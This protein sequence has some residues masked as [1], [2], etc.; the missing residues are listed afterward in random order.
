MKYLTTIIV[1]LT[2]F[3]CMEN[4]TDPQKEKSI[5]GQWITK[6]YY[7]GIIDITYNDNILIIEEIAGSTGLPNETYKTIESCNNI[8]GQSQDYTDDNSTYCYVISI[9]VYP[10]SLLIKP[11]F[12]TRTNNIT[13]VHWQDYSTW[14]RN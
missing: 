14:L 11:G 3:S 13:K 2:L 6:G 4:V 7:D 12:Q 5:N 1:L 9:D 8:Y 10:D